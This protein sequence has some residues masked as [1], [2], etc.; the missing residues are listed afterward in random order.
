MRIFTFDGG[1]LDCHSIEISTDAR[2]IIADEYRLLPTDEVVRIIDD[3]EPEPTR[4]EIVAWL[5][6]HEQV[7]EDFCYHFDLDVVTGEAKIE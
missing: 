5:S 6:E 3:K 7:W 2:A 1:K 4:E